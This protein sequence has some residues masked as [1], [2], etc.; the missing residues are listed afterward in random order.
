MNY[1]ARKLNNQQVS[2]AVEAG[3]VGWGGYSRVVMDEIS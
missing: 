1:R 3:M 2:A